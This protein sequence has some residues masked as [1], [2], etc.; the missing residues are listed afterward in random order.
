MADF[1]EAQVYDVFGLEPESEGT[2][3]DAGT[4]G[5]STEEQPTPEAEAQVEAAD[6]G[7]AETSTDDSNEVQANEEEAKPE[8]TPEERRENA[9]RRR[10]AEM[11][12]AADNARAEEQAKA[13]DF[14]KKANLKNTLTGAPITNFEDFDEWYTAFEAA[15]LQRDLKAGKL[16]PEA[17][18]K[19]IS[20]HPTV[21]KAEEVLQANRPQPQKDPAKEAAAQAQIDSEIAQ[22]HSMDPNISSVQDLLTMP[23]AEKFAEY[24]KRGNTFLDA[25]YLT[26]RE[27]LSEKTAAAA[28]QQATSNARSKDH[29][30]PA[31]NVR[32]A[33][34]ATVPAD[35][36]AMFRLLNPDAT[37]SEIQAYY[38]KTKKG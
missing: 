16:T 32:G 25:Y 3:S 22:I 36:M 28:R 7:T 29:L 2:A 34:A 33:G 21:K 17:L 19:A 27:R 24:V 26:N 11:Q 6:A 35:E 5:T 8:Q 23:G 1:T 20:N 15:K 13:A 12:E 31:G 4:A 10:R 37:D 30:T 14:F 18:D 9:A 38:N